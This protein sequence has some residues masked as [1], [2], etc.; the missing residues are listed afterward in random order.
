[1][2]AQRKFRPTSIKVRSRA[3]ALDAEAGAVRL[4]LLGCA[5]LLVPVGLRALLLIEQ[6]LAPDL[7]DL[8][9][10]LSDVTAALGVAV[11]AGLLARLRGWLGVGL[12]LLW[13]LLCYGNYEH[14]RANGANM[15]LRY[16]GYL[17]DATFLRG[18]ALAV[19]QPW[20]LVGALLATLGFGWVAL[21]SGSR[22]RLPTV[23]I[24]WGLGAGGGGAGF[25][26]RVSRSARMAPD[27][28]RDAKHH[29]ADSGYSRSR[30]H[31]TVDARRIRARPR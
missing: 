27:P 7:G 3:D 4:V 25:V 9:G 29:V 26:E 24:S 21:R 8:R 2:S 31:R 23:V 13:V 18:S 10:L 30:F 1:M 11:A 17:T 22:V 20:L 14:V 6:G 12:L 28:L 16:A 19:T 5:A 15:A